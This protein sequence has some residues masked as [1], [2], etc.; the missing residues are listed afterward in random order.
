MLYNRSIRDLLHAEV[1]SSWTGRCSTKSC[2]TCSPDLKP[3]DILWSGF[4][5]DRVYLARSANLYLLNR[6][7][8]SQWEE[9]AKKS[10]EVYKESLTRDLMKFPE[11][12]PEV[13]KLCI[14]DK[15]FN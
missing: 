15:N 8:P 2:L 13:L 1:P 12:T 7:I 14:I 9:I 3:R 11:E 6:N 4:V 5:K 10:I